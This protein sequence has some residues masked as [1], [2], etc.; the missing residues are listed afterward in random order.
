[1]TFIKS[2]IEK[3]ML[4]AVL[5]LHGCPS[6]GLVRGKPAII[7]EAVINFIF[8]TSWACFF[9]ASLPFFAVDIVFRRPRPPALASY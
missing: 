4:L 8:C 9:A 2:A 5:V 3:M 6:G 7:M 1:M